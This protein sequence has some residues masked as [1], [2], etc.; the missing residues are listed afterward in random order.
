MFNELREKLFKTSLKRSVSHRDRILGNMIGPMSIDPENGLENYTNGEDTDKAVVKGYREY[1][2]EMHLDYDSLEEA[3]KAL[4]LEEY[5]LLQADLY[6]HK[7]AGMTKFR[8]WRDLWENCEDNFSRPTIGWLMGFGGICHIALKTELVC[9]GDLP[10]GIAEGI[11]LHRSIVGEPLKTD[12]DFIKNLP[13]KEQDKIN[14]TAREL[15]EM[16][17]HELPQF[18]GDVEGICAVK[19][20]AK[21]AYL[22]TGGIVKEICEYYEKLGYKALEYDLVCPWIRGGVGA[23][24]SR[25]NFWSQSWVNEAG[26]IA[27]VC[28]TVGGSTQGEVTVFAFYSPSEYCREAVEYYREVRPDGVEGKELEV[29]E[30]KDFRFYPVPPIGYGLNDKLLVWRNKVIHK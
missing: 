10:A 23:G 14:E 9:A 19:Y 5:H 4:S 15:K 6:Y 3:K 2:Q 24:W 16:Y 26:D 28:L 18:H 12:G 22:P 7:M 13:K 30:Y 29:P 21:D 17:E 1:I 20:Y 8:F 27:E 25:G 11:Y